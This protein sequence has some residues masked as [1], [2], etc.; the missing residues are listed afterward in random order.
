MRPHPLALTLLLFFAAI[1]QAQ[2]KDFK[3]PENPRVAF[4][5]NTFVER[6][7]EHGYFETRLLLAFPDKEI[8]FRNLGWSGD[9]VRGEAR[10]G[11]GQ[12][13]DG[14]NRLAK[15][16]ADLKPNLI[17]L[18][19]G[20]NESWAGAAGL[21]TFDADLAKLL[22]AITKD[23]AQ[24]VIFSIMAQE[25]LGPPLPDPDAHNKDIRLYNQALAKAAAARGLRFVDLYD[26]PLAYAKANPGQHFTANEIH[27]TPTGYRFLA[28]AIARKLGFAE[29]SWSDRFEKIRKLTIEKNRLYFHRWRPENETYIFGFRKKEQGQNA[30]EIPRFDPL[31]AAKEAEINKLKK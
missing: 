31:I 28:E 26:L 16:V 17:F 29:S 30:V 19:Y 22:D 9:T 8:I 12:P 5:G 10:A 25:N 3:L 20:V 15:H 4:I 6:D 24:V 1:A 11:F 13:I 2:D 27:P 14:F 21:S 23:G 18:N 7:A